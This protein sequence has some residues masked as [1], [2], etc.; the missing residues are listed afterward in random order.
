MGEGFKRHDGEGGSGDWEKAMRKSEPV[1]MSVSL[2]EELDP[3]VADVTS[4]LLDARLTE[5]RTGVS[6]T[7]GVEVEGIS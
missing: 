7:N 3:A 5:E 6:C 2:S 4:R 1:S